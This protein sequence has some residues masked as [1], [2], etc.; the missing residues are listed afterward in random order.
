MENKYIILLHT[1]AVFNL[2]AA[3]IWTNTLKGRELRI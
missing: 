1:V 3:D 2:I